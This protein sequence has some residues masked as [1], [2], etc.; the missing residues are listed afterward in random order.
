MSDRIRRHVIVTGRVQGVGFRFH[1]ADEANRLGIA[2]WVRNL[3][4]SSVEA[5]FEGSASAVESMLAWVRVGPPSAEVTGV[6]IDDVALVTGSS[7]RRSTSEF[8]IR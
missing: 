1:T 5:E 7:G 4:D 8:R 3:P 2:G 6:D